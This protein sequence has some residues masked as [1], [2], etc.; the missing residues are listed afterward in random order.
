MLG[1]TL[2]DSLVPPAK[3]DDSIE[4][5]KLARSFLAK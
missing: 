2:I 3:Q 5:G 1:H 4:L